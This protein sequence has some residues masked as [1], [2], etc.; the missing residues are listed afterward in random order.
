M[1]PRLLV[2]V[3]RVGLLLFLLAGCGDIASVSFPLTP[4]PFIVSSDD[5]GLPAELQD[6]AV[7]ASVPCGPGGMC[8]SAGEVTIS[9]EASVCNPAPHTV[10][11]D[12]PVVDFDVPDE[13]RE[14]IT[15]VDRY[16]LE[17]V[18]YDVMVNS[19]SFDLPAVEI[20]WGPEAA[21]DVDPAM[22]VHLLGQ[23]PPTAAGVI[24]P[25]TMQVDPTGEA[26]L[27]DHLVDTSRRVRF[28]ARTQVDVEPGAPFPQGSLQVEVSLRVRAVGS[29]L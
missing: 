19:L 17:N 29:V 9:C 6:G 18:S 15:R 3:H 11:I 22:G 16:E 23:V 20:H 27:S 21:I 26:T 5:L 24:G 14:L 10:T 28:F 2:P 12:L 7:V 8:P 13:F 4:P 25:G 1:A